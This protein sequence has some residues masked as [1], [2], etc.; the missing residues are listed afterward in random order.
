MQVARTVADTLEHHGIEEEVWEAAAGQLVYVLRGSVQDSLA[1]NNAFLSGRIPSE[2]RNACASVVFGGIASRKQ[3]FRAV[4][5]ALARPPYI[6]ITA[7]T[8]K[9]VDRGFHFNCMLN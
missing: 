6:I 8:G 1:G 3:Q 2:V 4:N 9:G 7:L 5:H